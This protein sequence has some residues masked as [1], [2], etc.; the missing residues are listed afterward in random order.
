MLGP[1]HPTPP[2]PPVPPPPHPPSPPNAPDLLLLAP[3]PTFEW[4]L[5]EPCIPSAGV[6]L[7]F[8]LSKAAGRHPCR[9]GEQQP[10]RAIG[11]GVVE[12]CSRENASAA[13]EGSVPS[14]LPSMRGRRSGG[15]SPGSKLSGTRAALPA[16]P[17][18]HPS[19][20]ASQ[21]IP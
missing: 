7:S 20:G 21:S 12:G 17:P 4:P 1:P 9:D 11:A 13:Q 2:P 8:A 15:A 5:S 3:H 18:V 19:I 10:L 6:G 14:A 16:P